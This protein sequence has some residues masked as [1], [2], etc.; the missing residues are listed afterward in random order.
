MSISIPGSS[1]HQHVDFQGKK[2]RPRLTR[3]RWQAL[4]LRDPIQSDMLPVVAM[5][6]VRLTSGCAAPEWSSGETGGEAARQTVRHSGGY[7]AKVRCEEM[8][9]ATP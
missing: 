3:P 5:A 2:S 9:P 6:R 4:L 1:T 8:G 7:S